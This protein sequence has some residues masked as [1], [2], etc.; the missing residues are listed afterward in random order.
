M[1]VRLFCIKDNGVKA[2]RMQKHYCDD[3]S[4]Q[5]LEIDWFLHLSLN[6]LYAKPCTEL[7]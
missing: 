6:G 2:I 3:L 5:V 7:K 4:V 1:Q